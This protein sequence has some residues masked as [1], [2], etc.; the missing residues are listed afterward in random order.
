MFTVLPLCLMMMNILHSQFCHLVTK[1]QSE[2]IATDLEHLDDDEH[3][4]DEKDDEDE[5]D[6]D[7][8]DG[9]KFPLNFVWL[10]WD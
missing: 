5:N 10:L 4:D 6:D 9:K 3:D 2:P 7:E 8:D 1:G